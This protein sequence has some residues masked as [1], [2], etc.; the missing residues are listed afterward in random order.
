MADQ[1]LDYKI[2]VAADVRGAAEATAAIGKV[3]SSATQA[4]KTTAA[5][6]AGVQEVGKRAAEAGDKGSQALKQQAEITGNLTAGANVLSE[7]LRGNV[8]ALAQFP[9]VLRAIAV[10]TAANPLFAIGAVAGAVIVPALTR[11]KEG[12]QAQAAAAK[13][14]SARNSEALSAARAA[15]GERRRNE[16]AEQMRLIGTEAATATA[17]INELANAQIALLD[18]DEAVRLA[19]IDA[20]ERSTPEQKIRA[21]ADV[22]GEGR[23]RRARI[24]TDAVRAGQ[25]ERAEEI[26]RAEEQR[27]EAE[28]VVEARQ[29][30]FA[31]V[32]ERSPS[33]IARELSAAQEEARDRLPVLREASRNVFT[34]SE[35]REGFAAEARQ[36]EQREADLAKELADALEDAGKKYKESLASAKASLDAAIAQRD[37][38]TKTERELQEKNQIALRSEATQLEVLNAQNRSATRVD[39]IRTGVA[40]RDAR[41]QEVSARPAI[42]QLTGETLAPA[43]KEVASAAKAIPA[44]EAVNFGEVVAALNGF[45][46]KVV[47]AQRQTN[48]NVDQLATTVRRLAERVDNMQSAR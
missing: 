18:A 48:A 6:A 9:A 25:V 44:P 7:G 46:E 36:I 32:A 15:I 1:K 14:A 35:R 22:I 24:Q 38:L 40:I 4:G 30:V 19:E 43:V 45:G 26:R 39:E 37:A 34:S 5:A 33:V 12:W 17:R 11:I 27:A 28:A 8:R 42:N 13:E 23:A 47:A 2:N 3:E 10:A 20:D 16:T 41:S 21:R 29:R 31:Q